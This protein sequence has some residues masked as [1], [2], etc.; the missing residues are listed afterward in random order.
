[1]KKILIT[2]LVKE[3]DIKQSFKNRLMK[4]DINVIYLLKICYHLKKY[5]KI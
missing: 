5:K 3:Y 2:Y 1:M 4:K